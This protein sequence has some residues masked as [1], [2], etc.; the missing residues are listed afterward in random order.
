MYYLLE[1][2]RIIRDEEI[3][4]EI[5]KTFSGDL[6]IEIKKNELQFTYINDRGI[7]YIVLEPRKFKKQS[8]N[9]YDLIEFGDLIESDFDIRRVVGLQSD[10]VVV[11]HDCCIYFK[12]IL[13]IYKLDAQGNYIKVWEVKEDE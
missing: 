7:K 4:K 3:I 1:N 6:N 12:N 5:K 8:E 10:S 13:A 11:K 9:V 2:N